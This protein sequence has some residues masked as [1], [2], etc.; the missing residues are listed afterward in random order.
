MAIYEIDGIEFEQLLSLRGYENRWLN[1]RRRARAE[2]SQ[3]L[4][5]L[6]SKIEAETG[7]SAQ[8]ISTANAENVQQ[9]A[10]YLDELQ[11]L[12]QQ[13]QD[14]GQDTIH[15]M[16]R[17][18]ISKEWLESQKEI[19]FNDIEKGEYAAAIASE[20]N[21]RD[22]VK[23]LNDPRIVWVCDLILDNSL[24]STAAK[25]NEFFAMEV[26]GVA[27]PDELPEEWQEAA[28]T[29]PKAATNSSKK[30]STATTSKR[31]RTSKAT[32]KSSSAA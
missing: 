32:A 7:I 19:Y 21:R 15:L 28:E 5:A 16:L 14:D 11:S 31:K 13:Q 20:E 3:K 12:T 23:R 17:S 25:I 18:R 24:L 2:T 27:T 22:G 6:V 10:P 30:S 26:E 8:Q 29:N 9:L 1:E 4:L